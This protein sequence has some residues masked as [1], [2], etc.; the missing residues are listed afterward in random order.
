M[1]SRNVVFMVAIP[2]GQNLSHVQYAVRTW[3]HWCRRNGATLFVW[4]KPLEDVQLMKPTWQRYSS[5]QILE[6]H[7]IDC[8]RVAQVDADT[9]VRWDC[10]NFF[11]REDGGLGVVRDCTP[12]FQLR[13]LQAYQHFFPGVEVPW[14]DFFNAGVMLLERRHRPLCQAVLDFYRLHRQEL[15]AMEEPV[16][17]GSEQNLARRWGTDQTPVNFLV[18][19]EGVALTF[20]PPTFNLMVFHNELFEDFAFAEM[21]Y[22][23]HFSGVPKLRNRAMRLA[24][25]QYAQHYDDQARS[26]EPAGTS[27]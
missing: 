10:P 18:R 20:L 15:L 23:W 4:D 17:V 24:W 25:E 8:D 3:S 5:F 12:R 7:R 14:Y 1:S 6:Q 22:I 13:C 27:L 9:M 26:P 19:R 16:P 2:T 21:G 11:D